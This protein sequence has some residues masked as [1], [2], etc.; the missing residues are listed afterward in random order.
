[1]ISNPRALLVSTVSLAL[2]A[3]AF[4]TDVKVGDFE[5][6]NPYAGTMLAEAKVG[7]YLRIRM[8]FGS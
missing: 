8:S 6:T 7:G 4:A 5:I 2:P 3:A 1:M